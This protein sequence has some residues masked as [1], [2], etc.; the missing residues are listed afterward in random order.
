MTFHGR[1]V[2]NR[3]ARRPTRAAMPDPDHN[4]H[5]KSMPDCFHGARA[6]LTIAS[7]DDDTICVAAQ[8]NPSQLERTKQVSWKQHEVADPDA[9]VLEYTGRQPRT[10]TLELLF[11]GYETRT[12]VEGFVADLEDLMDAVH[13]DNLELRRPHFC[14]IAWG[15]RGIRPFRCVIESLVTKYSVFDKDGVPLRATC[16]LKV[17]EAERPISRAERIPSERRRD[18]S[19]LASSDRNR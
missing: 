13:L 6:K 3:G 19:A 8:Y 2:R 16:T 9:Q 18:L 1:E 4:I 5:L 12:S 10:L 11:D 14:V 17:T 15:D 7:L